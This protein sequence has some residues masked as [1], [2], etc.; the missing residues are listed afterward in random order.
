MSDYTITSTKGQEML[1]FLP[2]FYE[3]SKIMKAI[4]QTKGLEFDDVYLALDDILKQF[5]AETAT[6]GLD[7]WEKELDLSSYTGEPV[8]QRRSAVL[9]KLRGIGTVTTALIK[10][11]TESFD[12]GHVEVLDRSTVYAFDTY[13]ET[14]ID[15]YTVKIYFTDT[16]GVPPNIDDVKAAIEEIMP[17]H[18]AI[19]YVFNYLTWDML[20]TK[21]L[22]WDELDAKNLTWTDFENGTWITT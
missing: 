3:T 17:A 6:W 13:R 9:A 18:L 22:T 5:Y 20:E 2:K 11:V 16:L 14:S 21:N 1:G 4:L 8:D 15:A 19:V 7:I 12:S 10:S